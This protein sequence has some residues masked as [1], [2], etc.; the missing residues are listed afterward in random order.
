MT[1]LILSAVLALLA[2]GGVLLRKTYYALPLREL[3]RRAEGHDPAAAKLYSAVAYGAS[4]SGLLWL[5][6]ALAGSGSLVFLLRAVP[7]WLSLLLAVIVGYTAFTWLPRGRV[8]LLELR[9][10]VA[11]TPVLTWVLSHIYPLS[12]RVAGS[13]QRASV[14]GEHTG[15][16]E[17][18]DLLDLMEKQSAQADSRISPAELETAKRALKFSDQHV[19][20]ILTPARHVKTILANETV[21][22]ILINELYERGQEVV[23]VRESAGGPVV[24]LLECRNL[25]LYSTGVV[26][27]LMNQTVHYLHEND[28]LGEALRA[29]TVTNSPL[30]VVV[31]NAQEYVGIVSTK[32]VL[33]ALLGEL[34]EEGFD[35]YTDLSAVAARYTPAAIPVTMPDDAEEEVV[36]LA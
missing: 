8:T 34:P 21:G 30:F 20:D 15:L 5:I 36:E 16:F 27:D 26:R 18:D 19:R 6:V 11:V 24:G 3:K 35:Q 4:L 2:T 31:N 7:V 14:S 10:T 22:P 33:R 32:N 23:L 28:D 13:L 17:R 1:D 12:S 9:I 29:F 25:D